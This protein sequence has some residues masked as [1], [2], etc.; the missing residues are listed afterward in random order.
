MNE[1]FLLT[2]KNLILKGKNLRE[3]NNLKEHEK[4]VKVYPV[5]YKPD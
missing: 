4:S 1:E 2:L 5:V 3:L